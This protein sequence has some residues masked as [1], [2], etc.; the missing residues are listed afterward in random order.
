M[1]VKLY[2]TYLEK[3]L[4]IFVL[5]RGLQVTSMIKL[6]IVLRTNFVVIWTISWLV[7]LT[8]VERVSSLIARVLK[9]GP[10]KARIPLSVQSMGH[11]IRG[12]TDWLT[13]AKVIWLLKLLLWKVTS[14]V[15]VLRVLQITDIIEFQTVVE[16]LVGSRTATIC[17]LKLIKY[18]IVLIG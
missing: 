10:S 9:S 18:Q 3:S 7:A 8:F 2:T 11:L 16:L 4:N 5:E 14:W 13:L 15:I 17:H 1:E 12:V 6:S